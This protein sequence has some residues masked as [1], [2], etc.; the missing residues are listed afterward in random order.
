MVRSSASASRLL[1]ARPLARSA[2][3]L[4]GDGE[5]VRGDVPEMDGIERPLLLDWRASRVAAACNWANR[6]YTS[7]GFLDN[8]FIMFDLPSPSEEVEPSCRYS[9]VGE[10]LLFGVLP[11]EPVVRLPKELGRSPPATSEKSIWQSLKKASYGS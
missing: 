2:L 5:S 4:P 11:L 8:P 7:A 1:V 10:E 6:E 3:L 9:E